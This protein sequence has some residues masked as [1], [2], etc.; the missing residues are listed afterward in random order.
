MF[1]HI[2]CVSVIPLYTNGMRMEIMKRT[3]FFSFGK[4][5]QYNNKTINILYIC[6]KIIIGHTYKLYIHKIFLP[7]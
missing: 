7:L 6:I 1:M 3:F 5:Q 2:I 4:Q